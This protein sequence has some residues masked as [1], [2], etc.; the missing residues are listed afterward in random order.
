[1]PQPEVMGFQRDTIRKV[2]KISN[3]V[4]VYHWFLH[5]YFKFLKDKIKILEIGAAYEM[6]QLIEALEP[7]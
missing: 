7:L 5:L 1:M 6:A 4:W 3:I 2:S